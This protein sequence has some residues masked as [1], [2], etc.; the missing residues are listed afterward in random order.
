MQAAQTVHGASL[1]GLPQ[2][3]S[4]RSLKRPKQPLD[5][6]STRIWTLQGCVYTL[7][8]CIALTTFL[9]CFSDTATT[10]R[11]AG[12]SGNEV[13]GCFTLLATDSDSLGLW[14]GGVVVCLPFRLLPLQALVLLGLCMLISKRPKF[15]GVATRL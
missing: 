4:T 8:D 13:L 14:E 7:T 11:V 2:F 5:I 3:V 9:V 12:G 10:S 6:D 15:S 1:T